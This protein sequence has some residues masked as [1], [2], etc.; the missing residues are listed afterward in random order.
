M[1]KGSAWNDFWWVFLH[2]LSQVSTA[3]WI[4]TSLVVSFSFCAIIYSET[5]NV[6]IVPVFALWFLV[7]SRVGLE[8]VRFYWNKILTEEHKLTTSGDK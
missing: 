2:I 5:Q 4:A 8:W 3:I 1:D 7:M 6:Y